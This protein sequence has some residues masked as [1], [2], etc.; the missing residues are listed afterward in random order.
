MIRRCVLCATDAPGSRRFVD[1]GTWSGVAHRACH[2]AHLEGLRGDARA[3]KQL[4]E[5]GARI[6]ERMRKGLI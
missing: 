6:V 3:L 2:E 4:G 1:A 5:R